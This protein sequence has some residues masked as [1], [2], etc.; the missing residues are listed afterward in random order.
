MIKKL[1]LLIALLLVATPAWAVSNRD[2]YVNTA[3]TAGGDGTTNGTAGATR[4][5]ATLAAA[6]SAEATNLVTA[7]VVLRI[8][9]AGTT[10]DSF[11][12]DFTGYTT[13][14][15]RYVRIIGNTGDAAG[16]HAGIWSNS[17][18]HLSYTKDTGFTPRS[19]S[20]SRFDLRLE[21][22]QMENTGGDGERRNG[23]NLTNYTGDGTLYVINTLIRYNPSGGATTSDNHGFR[24]NASTGAIKLYL[25]NNVIYGFRE[26]GLF[27]DPKNS[28]EQLVLYNN[29]IAGNNL[30]GTDGV[31][32]YI[33]VTNTGGEIL[34]M[35]NNILSK[36]TISGT[37]ATYT[38]SNNGTTDTSSPDNTYD[39]Q[40]YSFVNTTL[41]T[42]DY[43]LQSSDTGAKD[44]GTDLSA[45]GTYAFSDDFE[46]VTRSG[47]WDQ[48]A[49]EY[50][51]SSINLLTIY[52]EDL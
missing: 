36:V 48:G 30:D 21:N 14:A 18:F 13:D 16:A 39:S 8:Y 38:H 28:G 4:A 20:G 42:A 49:D 35:K 27:W 6:I 47:T 7:D 5:Y 12:G 19:Y 34:I 29:T 22:L 33:D 23:I 41:A 3:S 10:A 26:A 24:A 31:E 45:D 11:D 37:P 51:S 9:C 46:R 40:T 1:I 44:K 2:R 50:A 43:H 15:T 32:V 52:S 25:I 17:Y